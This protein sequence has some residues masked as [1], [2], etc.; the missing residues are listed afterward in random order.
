MTP[1]S[2][3]AAP[4]TT[5]PSKYG[6]IINLILDVNKADAFIPK[7][8]VKPAFSIFAPPGPHPSHTGDHYGKG[9]TKTQKWVNKAVA[10]K[11]QA[12]LEAE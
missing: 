5:A 9:N 3:S 10:K 6:S 8:Q 2:K 4:G 12:E 11:D 1:A 7:I